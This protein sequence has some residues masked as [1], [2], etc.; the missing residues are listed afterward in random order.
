VYVLSIDEGTRSVHLRSSHDSGR[1][2][3][4]KS[5]GKAG[6][7]AGTILG[8]PLLDADGDVVVAAW[9]GEKAT[10]DG[11]GGGLVRISRD[12]GRTWDA[13][14][15]P[16]TKLR[17]I[18]VRGG[19]ILAMGANRAE[20]FQPAF[21]LTS[22]VEFTSVALPERLNVPAEARAI[23]GPSGELGLLTV[24]GEPAP[25]IQPQQPCVA[26]W[27][28]STDAG[29]TWS[30]PERIGEMCRFGDGS[31][32]SLRIAWHEDGRV[33]AFLSSVGGEQVIAARS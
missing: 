30:I 15:T 32:S 1:T 29:G 2:F 33:L 28:T 24:S 18:D 14:I 5:L 26:T 6:I 31:D 20:P 23:L 16:P 11:L 9:D 19:R 13:A 22:G 25:A 21:Y 3:T 12:A 10:W 4:S 17:E 8:A 27:R 7:D